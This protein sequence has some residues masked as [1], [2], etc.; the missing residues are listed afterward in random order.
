MTCP[1]HDDCLKSE[2]ARRADC[3]GEHPC[4]NLSGLACD[5]P[6]PAPDLRGGCS[7]I[8]IAANA[9]EVPR[10]SQAAIGGSIPSLIAREV[11]SRATDS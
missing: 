3:K 8:T 5:Y 11:L 9:G 6:S 4:E 2:N 7:R 10:S 1:C